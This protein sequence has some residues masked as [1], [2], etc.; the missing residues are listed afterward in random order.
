MGVPF[1]ALL[2][3]GIIVGFMT[4]GAGGIWAVKYWVNDYKQPRWGLDQ[5]DRQMMDRDRRI[6]GTFR[7]Q[8]ANPTAPKGFELNNPWKLEKRIF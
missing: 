3:F 2:P 8:S 1:E 7:G 6:T 5:W 4:A